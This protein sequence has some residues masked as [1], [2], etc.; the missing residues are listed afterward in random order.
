M[1]EEATAGRAPGWTARPGWAGDGSGRNSPR[2]APAGVRH[3]ARQAAVPGSRCSTA[4]VPGRR[5]GYTRTGQ[6]PD[7]T[8]AREAQQA[9]LRL[10]RGRRPERRT[11]PGRPAE[12]PAA[13]RPGPRGAAGPAG[14]GQS[15]PRSEGRAPGPGGP[16]PGRT[17]P[18]PGLASRRS[19]VSRRGN[20]RWRPP[21]PRARQPHPAEPARHRGEPVDCPGRPDARANPA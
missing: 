8:A 7:A 16:A 13:W 19:L 17:R 12:V 2:R 21:A 10:A 20:P 9:D 5:R 1:A 14:P 6:P 4:T 18:R 3:P 15:V 11:P